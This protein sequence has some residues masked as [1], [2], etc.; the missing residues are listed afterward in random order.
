MV[1]AMTSGSADLERRVRRL[2][3]DVAS[4]YEILAAVQLTQSRHTSRL[5]EIDTMVAGIDGKVDGLDGKVDGLD[6][7][8]DG[9]DQRLTRVDG[10]VDG[11]DGKVGGLDE[12]MDSVLDL[13][14][15]G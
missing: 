5:D 10:K 2:D 4:I 11:L 14:R 15:Q 13:L 3:N 8:V 9:L 12:K 1:T 7:K 6:G